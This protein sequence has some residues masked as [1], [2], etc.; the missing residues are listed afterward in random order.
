MTRLAVLQMVQIRDLK[1]GDVLATPS[2]EV[3]WIS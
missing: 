3:E 1:V 2:R